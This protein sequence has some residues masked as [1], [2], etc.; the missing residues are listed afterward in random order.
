MERVEKESVRCNA[1]SP[2]NQEILIECRLVCWEE[3]IVH[4]H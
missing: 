2:V 1:D 3:C 4:V